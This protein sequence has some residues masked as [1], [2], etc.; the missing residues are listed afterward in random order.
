LPVPPVAEPVLER[1][2]GHQGPG[3]VRELRNVL[4][5]A[6][7]LSPP[8]ALV[9]EPFDARGEAAPVSGLPF[10]ASLQEVVHAAAAAMVALTGGNKSEAARRLGIS[11]PRL[12]RLLDG[13]LD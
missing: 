4:E 3:N 5:R 13:T 11:R 2:R 1:L 10:P 8:G 6:V 7:V 9:L 12:Q